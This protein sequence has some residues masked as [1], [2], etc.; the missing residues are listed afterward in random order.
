M[1]KTL[2]ESSRMDAATAMDL[3]I[4]SLNTYGPRHEHWGIAWSRGKDSTSLLTMV[5]YLIESGKIQRPKSLTVL[6]AD[7]RLELT[8]LEMAAAEIIEALRDRGIEVRVVLPEMDKR[9]FVYMLGRGVPPPNNMTLRWCT[10]QMK[11]VPMERELR[12]LTAER[13]TG[14]KLLMLTGVRQGESAMRD[15][16]IAMSCGRDGA[17]CG[18]GWYQECLASDGVTTLAPLLHWRVCHIWHWLRDWAPQAQ[19]GEWPTRMLAEAYG[20]DEAEELN[21]RTGCI[22][23]PLASRDQAL[24]AICRMPQWSYLRPLKELRT[25]YE[26]LRLPECRLRQPGGE[27]RKDGTLTDNQHRMGPLTMDARRRALATVLGI[28]QRINRTAAESGRLPIDILNV[29]EADRIMEL[30]EANTWPNK[31]T[32]DEPLATEPFEDGTG[33]TL[34]DDDFLTDTAPAVGTGAAVEV[35]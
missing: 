26:H 18:Q 22:C 20:G 28:Q 11:I 10:P 31:W 19:F 8:P 4:A 30:M 15:G 25:L 17:E 16:R 32:G 6:S 12:R 24:D 9:F 27:R 2:Y 35:E 23:C 14:G 21:C 5:V 1:M 3:T 33:P 7:T 29:E 34:F 13:G